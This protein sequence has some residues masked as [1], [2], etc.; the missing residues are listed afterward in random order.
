MSTIYGD[1]FVADRFAPTSLIEAAE[2]AEAQQRAELRQHES[3]DIAT[4]C[5]REAMRAIPWITKRATLALIAC[6][7]DVVSRGSWSHTDAG[8]GVLEA[9]GDCVTILENSISRHGG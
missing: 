9:L 2:L 4:R 6:L 7:V 1:G 5:S 3:A 8:T